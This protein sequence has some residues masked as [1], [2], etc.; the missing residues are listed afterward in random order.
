[1]VDRMWT[2]RPLGIDYTGK[3]RYGNKV[4]GIKKE[5]KK[6]FRFVRFMDL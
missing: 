2:Y 4:T 5:E 6:G 3:K 1:M